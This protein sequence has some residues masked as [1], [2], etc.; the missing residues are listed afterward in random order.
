MRKMKKYTKVIRESDSHIQAVIQE[1]LQ[2]CTVLKR[3]NPLETEV[4]MERALQMAVANYVFELSKGIDTPLNEGSGGLS[5]GQAQRIAI[6]R[7]LFYLWMRRL[8]R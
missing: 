5:E 2:H 4:E 8:Q 6:A 3:W 1:S 7:S